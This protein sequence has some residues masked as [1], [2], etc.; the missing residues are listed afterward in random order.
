MSWTYAAASGLQTVGDNCVP[1]GRTTEH[2]LATGPMQTGCEKIPCLS[3]ADGTVDERVGYTITLLTSSEKK[4]KVL[5]L[6][7]ERPPSPKRGK[8]SGPPSVPPKS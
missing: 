3:A 8:T 2:G 1:A 6:I 4:K 7:T 5:P